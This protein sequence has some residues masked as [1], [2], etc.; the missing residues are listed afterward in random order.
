MVTIQSILHY[1]LRYVFLAD[2]HRYGRLARRLPFA[3][4]RDN[5]DTMSFAPP[6]N[7]SQS[8]TP[9]EQASKLSTGR[10]ALWDEH[11][12]SAD[13]AATTRLDRGG[14]PVRKYA[15]VKRVPDHAGDGTWTHRDSAGV[16][17]GAPC[18]VR[19]VTFQSEREGSKAFARPCRA[20]S[21]LSNARH[22]ASR[23]GLAAESGI[24]PPTIKGP[25][26]WGRY[27]FLTVFFG[28]NP[29]NN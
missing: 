26:A 9:L 6:S 21:K 8:N 5:R 11:A 29:K 20:A 17:G 25:R 2:G 16:R 7:Q 18:G 28:F 12:K 24:S 19:K 13:D 27:G 4:P 22:R 14:A 3:A 23:H 10:S 1:L 15:S